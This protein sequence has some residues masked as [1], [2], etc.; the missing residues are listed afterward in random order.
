[1][2]AE[3][4]VPDPFATSPGSR[5][6][7][8]GD[9][10]R[11]RPDGNIEFLGRVDHQVKIHGYRIELG[12]IETA[13]SARRD[14]LEAVVVA[15]EDQA[16][17]PMLAAYVVPA[18][19]PPPTADQFRRD[20]ESRLP[21]YMVPSAFVVLDELPLTAGG[22]VDRA[23]LPRPDG[24]R[25]NLETPFVAPRNEIEER[26]AGIWAEVLGIDRVGVDDDFFELGGGSLSSLRV[27]AKAEEAGIAIR[28][29]VLESESLEPEML[30]PELLFE[31]TTIAKLAPVLEMA[32][33]DDA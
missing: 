22:K 19:E 30:G 4:F 3:R 11:W 32:E 17:E 16:G 29:E 20:L 24:V 7:R 10:A 14:L 26:L 12:E 6:Y 23:A 31:Y 33:A 9:L 18:V 1:L 27:I 25:P 21:S 28:P 8:T 2:T 5:L 15:R 13:L